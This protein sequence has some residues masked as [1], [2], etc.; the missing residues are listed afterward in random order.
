M[1]ARCSGLP[2]LEKGQL[3]GSA[4][5]LLERLGSDNGSGLGNF[6]VSRTGIYAGITGGGLERGG[7]L[8]WGDAA[9][10]VHPLPFEKNVYSA[11]RISPDG[12][13]FAVGVGQPGKVDTFVGDLSSGRLTQVTFG[14]SAEVVIWALDGKHLVVQDDGLTKLYWVSADGGSPAQLLYAAAAP[15][16]TVQ[17]L[18]FLPDGTSLIVGPGKSGHEADLYRLPIDLRDPDHPKG[19]LPERILTASLGTAALS[20]DGKWLAY[21]ARIGDKT[22][23]YVEPFPHTGAKWRVPE[24]GKVVDWTA[25]LLFYSASRQIAAVRWHAQGNTF[26]TEKAVLWETAS[27]LTPW[28]VFP[29]GKRLLGFLRDEPRPTQLTFIVNFADELRRRVPPGK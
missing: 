27:E 2:D 17:P 4:M 28:D 26:V 1:R 3:T 19:G 21:P 22:D 24:G 23:L 9:G 8:A 6:D 5:P 15:L 13:H 25:E 10:K 29:D 16:A 11:L 20:P 14:L 12:S 18:S 7:S